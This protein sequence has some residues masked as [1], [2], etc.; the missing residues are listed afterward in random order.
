MWACPH[1]T[2]SFGACCF[3]YN[4]GLWLSSWSHVPLFHWAYTEALEGGHNG[5]GLWNV[6]SQSDW[7]R[8]QHA[9]QRHT[10]I[11]LV[12]LGWQ[13]A[14]DFAWDAWGIPPQFTCKNSTECDILWMSPEAVA[15]CTSVRILH[16]FADHATLVAGFD[17][18]LPDIYLR[19]WSLPSAIPWSDVD[20]AWLP[21]AQPPAWDDSSNFRCWCKM[22][23]MGQFTGRKLD[24]FSQGSAS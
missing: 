3:D 9:L 23:A 11:W 15:L 20:S 1:F 6:W 13:S 16:Q 12:E 21:S 22:E 4:C 2:S 10:R 5:S 19:Q 7:R 17:I 14:Q 18:S 8:L 24:R